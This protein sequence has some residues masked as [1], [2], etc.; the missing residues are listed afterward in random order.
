MT[1]IFPYAY[2]ITCTY[3]WTY[4]QKEN[5]NSIVMLLLLILYK[6][7]LFLLKISVSYIEQRSSLH[8]KVRG[9]HDNHIV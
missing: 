9:S 8:F 5:F 1:N 3:L 2:L 6:N 7:K 4:N